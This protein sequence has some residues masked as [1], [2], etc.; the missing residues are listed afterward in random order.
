ME[1]HTCWLHREKHGLWGVGKHFTVS[2]QILHWA[3]N[4][5]A[6]WNYKRRGGLPGQPHCSSREQASV[7]PRTTSFYLWVST[8]PWWHPASLNFPQQWLNSLPF[9][10][11]KISPPEGENWF[12][13][14][15]VWDITVTVALQSHLKHIE[16]HKQIYSISVVL[17]FHRM[18]R[19][20]WS[21]GGVLG[22]M[23]LM[24]LFRGP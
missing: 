10:W 6:P 11:G 20:W 19:C 5:S 3:Q 4:I 14:Q 17:R 1:L 9:Q 23:G 7:S 2:Q 21:N 12:W 16:V 22:K 8:G 18:G 13:E 24:G 15:G